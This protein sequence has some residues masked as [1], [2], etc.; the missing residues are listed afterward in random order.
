MDLARRVSEGERTPEARKLTDWMRGQTWVLAKRFIGSTQGAR[1]L[2]G[3][4]FTISLA[5]ASG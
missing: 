4:V 2:G 3:V 1:P 5:H